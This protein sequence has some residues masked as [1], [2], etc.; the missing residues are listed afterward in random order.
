MAAILHAKAPLYIVKIG[1]WKKYLHRKRV[2]TS[3]ALWQRRNSPGK[4]TNRPRDGMNWA[5]AKCNSNRG[6]NDRGWAWFINV[7]QRKWQGWIEI[8]VVQPNFECAYSGVGCT[9]V[10]TSCHV[11]EFS[12][13]EAPFWEQC[14]DAQLD[15][16]PILLTWT[17]YHEHI[18]H[19]QSISCNQFNWM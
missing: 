17:F 16:C 12:N 6:R 1:E 4:G 10:H 7:G 9:Q 18:K 13:S 15:Q 11:W 19:I 8:M 14:N 5:W 3:W 2:H